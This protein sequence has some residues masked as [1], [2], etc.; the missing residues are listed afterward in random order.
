MTLTF[1][2]D[3]LNPQPGRQALEC[4]PN[5]DPLLLLP[6]VTTPSFPRPF[7]LSSSWAAVPLSRGSAPPKAFPASLQPVRSLPTVTWSS[8]KH[9]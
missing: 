5:C 3:S 7:S 8:A 2:S 9:H 4:G 1:R 6:N